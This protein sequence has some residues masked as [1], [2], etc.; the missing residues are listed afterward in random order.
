MHKK[1]VDEYYDQRTRNYIRTYIGPD[2]I[3]TQE[4]LTEE[5]ARWANETYINR[6]INA[7]IKFKPVCC[8]CGAPKK[9]V[10]CCYCKT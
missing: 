10:I 4:V 9:A 7:T 3:K 8:N 5:R 2:G 6:Q 1:L